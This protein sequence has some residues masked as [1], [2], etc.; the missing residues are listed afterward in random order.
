MPVAHRYSRVAIGLHWLIALAI[1]GNLVGGLTLD[2]FLD[3][4]DPAM[5]AQGLI[6][7]GLHK[8]MGLT[9]IVLTLVRIGWRLANPPPPLPAHMTGLERV[10][11]R[12]THGGFYA[13]M[14][15]LPLS[16]WALVSTGRAPISRFGLFDVPHLP[17]VASQR[18]LFGEGHELL[19]W[20]MIAMLALHMLAASKH[21]VLDRDD[22]LASMLPLVRRRH[23]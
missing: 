14:L 21:H 9:I 2:L 18:G 5:K 11:A 4:A 13:L 23:G 16:G 22:V 1:I 17:V 15:V 3:S 19:G 8:S 10:L 12:V 20:T 7:I 6:N